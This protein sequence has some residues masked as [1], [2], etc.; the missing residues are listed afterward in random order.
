VS[1]LFLWSYPRTVED[2]E[3]FLSVEAGCGSWTFGVD[4]MGFFTGQSPFC[5]THPTSPVHSVE[6][7][8][9]W[10][11]L[12]VWPCLMDVYDRI[13]FS[14]PSHV[15]LLQLVWT[16]VGGIGYK[17]FQGICVCLLG[18]SIGCGVTMGW[19]IIL[20]TCMYRQLCN[21]CYILCC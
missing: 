7:F 4:V 10:L 6:F 8:M 5:V 1:A 17:V 18:D 19:Y 14:V 13:S 12:F 2:H 3:H 11:G 20:T 21:L 16:F 9:Y 15:N